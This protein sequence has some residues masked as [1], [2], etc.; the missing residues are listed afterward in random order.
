MK[1]RDGFQWHGRLNWV[2]CSV[3]VQFPVMDYVAQVQGRVR[4]PW[5]PLGKVMDGSRDII[6]ERRATEQIL[7]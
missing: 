4:Y 5:S 2:I 3:V 1:I 6:S 7:N